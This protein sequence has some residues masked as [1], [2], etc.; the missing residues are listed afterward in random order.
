MSII[1]KII[2]HVNSM[3]L[4]TRFTMQNTKSK[5]GKKNE[6]SEFENLFSL[7]IMLIKLR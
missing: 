6:V 4:N 5:C 7:I 3:S 2:E 1:N